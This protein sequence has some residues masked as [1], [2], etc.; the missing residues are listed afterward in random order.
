VSENHP[1]GPRWTAGLLCL[2]LTTQA[3]MVVAQ[4]VLIGRYLDGNFDQLASHSLNGSVLP[5][6]AM[7]GIGAAAVHWLVGR[8]RFWPVPATAL[9]I[10]VEGM[11]LAA[12]YSHSLAIHIPLGTAIVGFA[13]F[14]AVWSWTPR[15]RHARPPRPRTGS[16]GA[17]GNTD[18]VVDAT[19]AQHI[20]GRSA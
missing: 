16:A 12:G 7:L 19:Q 5:A 6:V 13:V 14:L 15:A 11:Q 20:P 2:L 1:R 4:P 8:G 17:T 10:P 9:L 18:L 3:A